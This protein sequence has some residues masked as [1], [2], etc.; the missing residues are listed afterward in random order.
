MAEQFPSMCEVLGTTF[1]TEEGKW[2]RK[3]QERAEEI[4]LGVML[5]KTSQ[6]KWTR[7]YLGRPRQQYQKSPLHVCD[8]HVAWSFMKACN[9]NSRTSPWC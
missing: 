2:R 7:F 6:R 5:M 3:E 4:I 8:S 9:S 1:S